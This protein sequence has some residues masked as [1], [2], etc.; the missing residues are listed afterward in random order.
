[1]TLPSERVVKRDKNLRRFADVTVSGIGLNDAFRDAQRD[2]LF[3]VGVVECA[4]GENHAALF[5]LHL[6]G[7]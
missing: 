1:M 2:I 6:G 5:R 4:V 7:E 3:E